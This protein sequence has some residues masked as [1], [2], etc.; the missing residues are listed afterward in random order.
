MGILD[1]TGNLFKLYD[2]ICGESECPKQY[3][4]WACVAGIAAALRDKC[5]VE[6][7]PGMPLKPNLYV[8]LIG[9]GSLGKGWAISQIVSIL[10]AATE[11]QTYRGKLTY[12]AL[13]DKLGKPYT[14]A[15]GEKRLA[16]PVLLLI[17][18]ELKNAVGSNK[19]LV[20][21]LVSQLTELYTATNYQLQT[22]TRKDGEITV[23]KSCLCWLFGSTPTW[24]KHVLTQDIFESGF[25][26]RCCFIHAGYNLKKRIL[27]P[28]YPADREKIFDHIQ[29]RFYHMTL[30]YQGEFSIT[31]KAEEL[32][33]SWYDTRDAPQERLL[34]S[35]W[36]RQK[37]LLLRFCMI[38]CVADGGAMMIQP[39]HVKRSIKMVKFV[40]QNAVHLLTNATQSYETSCISAVAE[41][42]K[43]K[44]AI[45]KCDLNRYFSSNRG[46]SAQ[47]V[48]KA[49]ADLIEQDLVETKRSPQ[50]R[51]LIY[52][53]KT[54]KEKPNAQAENYDK[55]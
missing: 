36:Y 29:Q 7:I 10:N 2:Y 34:Y 25:I 18:D 43:A 48:N 21:E 31:P 33:L 35:I 12:A 17:M 37:E 24:L 28:R 47:R 44:I 45:K 14:N 40:F 6:I 9:P 41:K 49:V 1:D 13:I 19:A 22:S 38:N 42:I 30:A 53:W 51:G 46:L 52:M 54:P 50:G 15:L 26:A 5:W 11:T 39:I 16:N 3:H 23:D 4:F 55:R 27:K 8:G 20:E 32:I